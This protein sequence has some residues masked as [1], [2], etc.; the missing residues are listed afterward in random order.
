[1]TH[2]RIGTG[3]A[4]GAVVALLLATIGL[5]T[6]RADV[7]AVGLPLALCAAM[8]A[9]RGRPD[10]EPRLA[11]GPPA[12]DEADVVVTPIRVDSEGETAHVVVSLAQTAPRHVIVAPGETIEARSRPRHSGPWVPVA[13]T[14]RAIDVDAGDAGAHSAPARNRDAVMPIARPI[15]ALPVPTRLTGLHGAHPGRRAGQGGDFR[16]IHPFAPGDELRRVDWKATARL[17]RRA[18]DLYVRRVDAM[19]DA[20][21]ALVVDA[22]V[23][24]GEVV[25]T[26]ATGDPETSGTTSLDLAREAARS[27]AAAAVASGDRVGLIELGR[28][29][30][31]VRAGSGARQLARLVHEI[32]AIEPRDAST[33]TRMPPVERGAIV[34]VAATF[35]EP[36][37]V[38]LALRWAA[39]GHRVVAID[40]LPRT[41]PSRLSSAE[42]LGLRVVQAQREEVVRSL[43][44]A[45]VDVVR[46]HDDGARQL[47][48]LARR[49][50]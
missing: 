50:A 22:T 25:G 11:V 28:G 12:H 24:V 44:H 49:R 4:A 20:S 29:G 18:G 5:L 30:R 48:L 10:P 27:V 47:D 9:A 40:V 35:L 23:D 26:W 7:A 32:S 33:A 38:E 8:G 46:W 14:V 17:S 42:L 41:D 39:V 15:A 37:P 19:S 16:D 1:M 6:S 3:V 45:R 2:G 36:A 21:V 31:V 13:A 34:Y 43:R